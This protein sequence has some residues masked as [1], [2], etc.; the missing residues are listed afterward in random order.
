[1]TLALSTVFLMLLIVYGFIRVTLSTPPKT[2]KRYKINIPPYVYYGILKAFM[3][4]T[5]LPLVLVL[6]LIIG[7]MVLTFKIEVTWI[8]PSFRVLAFIHKNHGMEI[9]KN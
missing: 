3:L 8:P 6:D 5:I 4:I 2:Y 9:I 7:I 1:M